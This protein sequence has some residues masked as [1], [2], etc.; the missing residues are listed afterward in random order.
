MRGRF[1]VGGMLL[2]SALMVNVRRIQRYLEE[3]AQMVKSSQ[4]L[5]QVHPC[6]LFC[7]AYGDAS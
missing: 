3:Q 4:E 5:R 2:G 7:R 1:R 6:Q